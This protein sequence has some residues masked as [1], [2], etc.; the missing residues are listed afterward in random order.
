MVILNNLEFTDNWMV[1]LFN[2]GKFRD[3]CTKEKFKK[4]SAIQMRNVYDYYGDKLKI[5]SMQMLQEYLNDTFRMRNIYWNDEET[6]GDWNWRLIRE[7][8]N[9]LMKREH[10]IEALKDCLKFYMIILE[11]NNTF[12]GKKY[13]KNNIKFIKEELTELQKLN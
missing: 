8:W 12:L 1:A 10:K 13:Y 11:N 5:N 9:L 6:I 7:K 3:I 2:D 4:I